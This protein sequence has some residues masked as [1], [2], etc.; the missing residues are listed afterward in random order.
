MRAVWNEDVLS[1]GNPE[2]Q[3]HGVSR[4]PSL[5]SKRPAIFT[6][7]SRGT[8]IMRNEKGQFVAGHKMTDTYGI[9]IK[10]YA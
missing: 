4:P 1:E 8:K 2:P 7:V 9:Q 3:V 6:R 5:T 10:K